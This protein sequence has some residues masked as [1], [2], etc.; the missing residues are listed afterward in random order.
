MFFF[1]KKKIKIKRNKKKS[2]YWSLV[3]KY[4]CLWVAKSIVI[5]ILFL[6]QEKY[7]S[8]TKK[9]KRPQTTTTKQIKGDIN[10]DC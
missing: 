5:L 2:Q 8:I 3:A 4:S 6:H 1:F 10:T 7:K 9:I